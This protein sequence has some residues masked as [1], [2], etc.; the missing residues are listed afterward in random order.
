M[1]QARNRMVSLEAT[2]FYH[3]VSRCVRRQ[4]L[5]G[6]DP[7]TGNDYSYRKEA[8]EQRPAL[9]AEVFAIDVCAYAVMSNHY[10]LVLHV[11]QQSALEW[12]ETEVAQRWLRLFTGP[13]LVRAYVAGQ[14]LTETQLTVVHSHI[15]D[16]RRRLHDISWFMKCLN[17]SIARA[18]NAEAN[19]TVTGHF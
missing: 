7:L 18:A 17:E 15:Q 6:E 14:E 11:D 9:L 8:I 4:F 12:D 3:A 5:C 13:S 2:P 10:H 19:V 1:P 16:Y